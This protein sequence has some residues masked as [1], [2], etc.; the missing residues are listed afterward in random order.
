[1]VGKEDFAPQKGFP[2][3]R[4][5]LSPSIPVPSLYLVLPQLLGLGWWHKGVQFPHLGMSPAEGR[6]ARRGLQS[7]T[8]RVVQSVSGTSSH[9]STKALGARDG[10]LSVSLCSIIPL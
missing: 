5:R 9:A 8:L 3:R 10:V 1:M 7:T 6:Q 4:H 2:S